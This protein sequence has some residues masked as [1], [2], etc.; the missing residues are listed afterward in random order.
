MAG[1]R[2][3]AT[4]NRLLLEV[5]YQP[6]RC[7]KTSWWC[8]GWLVAG[9]RVAVRC[10][11]LIKQSMCALAAKSSLVLAEYQ[12]LPISFQLQ[13]YIHIQSIRLHPLLCAPDS[14]YSSTLL[15]LVF[16]L[17]LPFSPSSFYYLG[18]FSNFSQSLERAKSK[19]K[20]LSRITSAVYG[21]AVWN[22]MFFNFSLFSFFIIF[23]RFLATPYKAKFS[24]IISLIWSSCL[25]LPLEG[26]RGNIAVLLH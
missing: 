6:V 26:G 13:S 1:G 8:L 11:R 21:W 9:V 12:I 5:F 17:F 16:S 24:G 20:G 19:Q 15:F 23:F 14:A 7:E 4:D 25:A 2:S 18:M 22:H 3:V 10:S